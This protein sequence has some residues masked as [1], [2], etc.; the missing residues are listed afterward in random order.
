MALHTPSSPAEAPGTASEAS[1]APSGI[2]SWDVVLETSAPAQPRERGM[3]A[4]QTPPP[5]RLSYAVTVAGPAARER[6]AGTASLEWRTAGE[7]YRLQ[8]DGV[9]GVM[10]VLDARGQLVDGGFVP[11]EVRGADGADA[12]GFDWESGR[13]SFSHSGRVAGIGGDGQDRA[14]MLMRL[15]GIGLAGGGQLEGGIE[16]LVAGAD[17]VAPV[18]FDHLGTETLAT[19]MGPIAAVHLRQ[20][21]TAS[22]AAT[23]AAG[24]AAAPLLDIWLSPA[25]DWYPVQLRLTAADGSVVTQTVTAI[26]AAGATAP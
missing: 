10:G 14:S 8:L 11:L 23:A 15:A 17:G 21:A 19:A 13:A 18:R 9:N 3:Q 6:Q 7:G 1:A 22:T 20:R 2:A 12:V 25:H 16:L 5:A 4:V 26:G 24:A